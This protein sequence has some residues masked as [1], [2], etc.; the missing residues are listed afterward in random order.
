MLVCL[1]VLKIPHWATFYN[2]T[3]CNLWFG[4]KWSSSNCLGNFECNNCFPSWWMSVRVVQYSVVPHSTDNTVKFCTLWCDSYLNA[5]GTKTTMHTITLC[6]SFQYKSPQPLPGSSGNRR[7]C[8]WT[9]TSAPFNKQKK[10]E[11]K[12][13][14]INTNLH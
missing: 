12:L 10:E 9:N 11:G 4:R 14:L 13:C 1:E 2:P 3:D 7:Y 5:F 6:R 8:R